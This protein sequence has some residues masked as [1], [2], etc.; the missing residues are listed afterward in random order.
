MVR[1]DLESNLQAGQKKRQSLPMRVWIAPATLL[2]RRR[3]Y[4]VSDVFKTLAC[5]MT[6]L[7]IFQFVWMRHLQAGWVRVPNDPFDI[8]F[9]DNVK[10]NS[11]EIWKSERQ[12]FI[13][14][15]MPVPIHSH[16]DYW[17]RIPLF[18]ALGSGCISVEAD[19]HLHGSDL[20]VGHSSLSLNRD[21]TL[22]SMYLEPLQRMLDMQNAHV[23]DGTWRGIFDKSPQQTV[24][25]L[26]DHKTAG[27]ETFAELDVQLQPL[28]DRDYL[29][30]WNGTE[31]VM[32]PL[33]IVAT[34]NAPFESVMAMNASHR[35]IFWDA[36]LHSL[37]SRYDNF[38][39]EPPVYGYNRS[40]SYFAS[41]QFKNGRLWAW[42]DNSNP[43][44]DTP[45]RRDREASQIEQA[46]ARGLVARYWD[47]P[48]N[49][50]NLRDIA[51]RVLV[52][53]K[54]GILNMDDLGAVRARASGWGQ[55]EL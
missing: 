53:R 8:R 42:H 22:R 30:Y 10:W 19:V 7:C 35:D 28:R 33:T 55:I 47:T 50:P 20:L 11:P 18:E 44:P 16:N 9:D 38:D 29:T 3:G 52:E 26:I 4:L 41:T 15:A 24:V 23:T 5:V 40:N 21:S 36:P 51:W 49:P 17:R 43:Q 12:A 39:V 6:A 13:H 2:K 45:S 54:V 37:F 34:G 14:S 46:K 31:R 25:L 27:P 1:T 32:R 48:S